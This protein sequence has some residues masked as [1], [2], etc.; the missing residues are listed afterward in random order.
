M[1]DIKSIFLLL[2]SSQ[3]L[4]LSLSLFFSSKRD[5]P[6]P[7]LGVI[8]AV[9]SIELLNSWAA[10]NNYHSSENPIP[11]WLLGSYLLLPASVW[12]LFKFSTSH[13]YS[14]KAILLFYIPALI[15]IV[16]EI[17]AFIR[18][19]ITGQSVELQKHTFW[20][21]FT[22]ILPVIWMASILIQFGRVLYQSSVNGNKI[23]AK[24]KAQF[25]VL[26]ALTVLWFLQSILQLR[27]F[28]YIEI[29]LVFVLFLLAYLGYF[30]PSLFE[31]YK[32]GSS[33]NID[34]IFSKEQIEMAISKLNK[35]LDEEKVYLQPKLSLEQLGNELKLQPRYISS[36]IQ[37]HY[38]QS[39]THLINN[40]RVKE[41]LRKI[42]DPQEKNKT[43]LA[44]ALESG[45]NSKSSFNQIFKEYTGKTPSSFLKES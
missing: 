34:N 37:S 3:G 35:M 11:F 27:V 26:S 25:S 10:G 29:F 42:N 23:P 43:L 5:R 2:A 44:L 16:A 1:E 22:E 31:K 14:K 6:N 12:L 13:T 8:I 38:Q 32:V 17:F 19:K 21:L 7:Y 18:F 33:K 24:L 30:M 4:L 40:Y 45:F 20:F 28:N 9:I 15:E 39:F 41:V 36:I